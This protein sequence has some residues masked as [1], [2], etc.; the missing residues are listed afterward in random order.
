MRRKALKDFSS[1]VWGNVAAGEFFDFEEGYK[2]D[3]VSWGV[4]APDAPAP[5]VVPAADG[6]EGAAPAA[7]DPKAAFAAAL[8]GQSVKR[9]RK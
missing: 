6:G 3:L 5:V 8:T 1:T 4:I 9:G 7:D 2:A